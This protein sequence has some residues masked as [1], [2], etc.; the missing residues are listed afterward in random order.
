M[1]KSRIAFAIAVVAICG[2]IMNCN[3]NSN[4]TGPTPPPDPTT[5]QIIV[6]EGFEGD[7][8]NYRQINYDS[9]QGM[10]SI[11][12]QYAHSGK[13]SLTSDSNNTGIKRTVDPSIH[14]SIAGLQFYLMATKDAHTDF[15]AA[16]CTPGSSANG[17][18][19]ILGMGIDKSDSL[20]YVYEK[21][22]L[23]PIN[24]HKN[25]AALTLNKWYK[26]KI[27]YDFT[28]TTLTYYLDDAIVHTQ[29]A[30]NLMTLEMFVVMRD[31]LGAQGPSGYYL[32][33]VIIY[34]R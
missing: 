24:E 28:D 14:D 12:T 6:S 33:D 34:K 4:P 11:S 2:M 22:P 27:E 31:S 10:M 26:C 30:S 20:R 32:D 5:G 25:F 18:Y 21:D 17:L 3:K 19:S 16:I 8:S 15:M 9:S 23:D 7:L 29:P 13:A 1:T